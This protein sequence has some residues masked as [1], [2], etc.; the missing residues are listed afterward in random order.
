[1]IL[2]VM[3]VSAMLLLPA[4]VNAEE[5]TAN[6]TQKEILS[7]SMGADFGKNLKKQGLDIDQDTLLKGMKDALSNTKL[8]VPESE[9][10]KTMAEFQLAQKFR[11][12]AFKKASPEENKKRGEA[13]LAENGIKPDV[14]TLPNGIQYKILKAGDGRKPADTDMVECYH[15]GTLIDGME[16]DSSYQAGQPST[17]KVAEALYPG[18]GKALKLMPAGSKWLFFIPSQLAYGEQGNG[19]GIGPNEMLIYEI[20]LLA[21]K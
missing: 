17:F 19:R 12:K 7:Y 21:V 1:M 2:K 20:E 16:F 3:A 8:L 11:R 10:R 5:P 15:R 6:M 14:V 18:L 4:V 9:I 13:F